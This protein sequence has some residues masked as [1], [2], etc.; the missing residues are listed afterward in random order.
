MKTA[1]TCATCKDN[2]CHVRETCPD[3]ETST[4]KRLEILEPYLE[5]TTQWQSLIISTIY[6]AI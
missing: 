4:E 6:F 5:V 1:F 3:D 2:K